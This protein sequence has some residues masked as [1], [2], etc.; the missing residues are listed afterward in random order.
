[1]QLLPGV[2]IVVD[3]EMI[4]RVNGQGVDVIRPQFV[5]DFPGFLYFYLLAQNLASDIIQI[6]AI[7]D[8]S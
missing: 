1:M 3:Q 8:K 7:Y 6:Y 5:Q 2:V 4:L